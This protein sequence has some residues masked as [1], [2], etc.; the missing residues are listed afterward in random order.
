MICGPSD[1]NIFTSASNASV[2]QNT[3]ASHTFCQQHPRH[4]FPVHHDMRG[5]D[6]DSRVV[7]DTATSEGVSECMTKGLTGSSSSA[8]KFRVVAP[9]D[10]NMVSV[11]S[12]RFLFRKSCCQPA[13]ST[14]PPSCATCMRR[15]HPQCLF[16]I[17]VLSS[18][19]YRFQELLCAHDERFEIQGCST[20]RQH[21]SL[22]AANASFSQNC[23]LRPA[24]FT[25]PLSCAAC[26]RRLPPQFLPEVCK[27]H[28]E[29]PDG[30]APSATSS[31]QSRQRSPTRW[32][33]RHPQLP[34][35]QAGS[36]WWR[37]PRLCRVL[38]H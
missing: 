14:L 35:S 1:E 22:V 37:W 38:Q 11:G 30:S 32:A 23:W 20:R 13:E 7:S 10:D 29:G 21:F 3:C 26:L 4:T 33:H 25:S 5:F 17:V 24:V 18:G 16:A 19:R 31:S 28:D 6:G 34:Q 8:M 12:N 27:A 2:A 9:P 36:G 15:L